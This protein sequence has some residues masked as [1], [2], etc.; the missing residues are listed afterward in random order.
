MENR[1]FFFFLQYNVSYVNGFR[2][3][4]PFFPIAT[5]IYDAKNMLLEL[6]ANIFQCHAL[7]DA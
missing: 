7:R 5:V 1:I 3:R 2:A 6:I 4:S